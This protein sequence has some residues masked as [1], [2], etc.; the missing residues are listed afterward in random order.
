MMDQSIG[1]VGGMGDQIFTVFGNRQWGVNVVLRLIVSSRSISSG[2]ETRRNFDL[3]ARWVLFLPCWPALRIPARGM[4]LSAI[5]SGLHLYG[6]ESY[7]SIVPCHHL[8]QG[9]HGRN[10]PN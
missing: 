5:E 10:P 4:K 9:F 2:R 3:M 7:G 1:Q 6:W 8:G